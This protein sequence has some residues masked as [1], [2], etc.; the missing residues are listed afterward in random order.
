MAMLWAAR[1][2]RG[3]TCGAASP[4]TPTCTAFCMPPCM[5]PC[6]ATLCTPKFIMSVPSLQLVE[7]AVGSVLDVCVCSTA[8]Q[9]RAEGACRLSVR[10]AQADASKYW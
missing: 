6:V 2:A 9:G 1:R 7:G 4:A 8:R 5:P 3:R 10:G